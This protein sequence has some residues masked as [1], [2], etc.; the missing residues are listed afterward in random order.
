MGENFTNGNRFIVENAIQ[1][2]RRKFYILE[3]N[4][5]NENVCKTFGENVIENLKNLQKKIDKL[6]LRD[7]GTVEKIKRKLE[8][9]ISFE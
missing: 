1:N 9:S 3:K 5:W 4:F 2:I 8:N 6:F 7:W